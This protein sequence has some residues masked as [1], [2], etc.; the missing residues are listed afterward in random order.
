MFYV[1]N[2]IT[3]TITLVTNFIL[4][5]NYKNRWHSFTS[6]T[7]NCNSQVKPGMWNISS[8]LTYKLGSTELPLNHSC[9]VQWFLFVM[10]KIKSYCKYF[11]YRSK[12]AYGSPFPSFSFFCVINNHCNTFLS[13]FQLFLYIFTYKI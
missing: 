5:A 3:F 8:V 10:T 11:K 12:N 1:W 6:Q 7:R 13:I 2:S 9:S 4:F